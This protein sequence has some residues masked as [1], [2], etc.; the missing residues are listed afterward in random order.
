M[1]AKPLTLDMI[2]DNVSKRFTSRYVESDGCW[3]WQGTRVAGYGVL[4]IGN[5]QYKAHR[6]AYLLGH[7]KIREDMV[8]DH[9]CDNRA[10]VKPSHLKQVT[11]REN[12]TRSDFFGSD[13]ECKRGHSGNFG[14]NKKGARYCRDC[15]NEYQRKKYK[16]NKFM[17]MTI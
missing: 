7:G 2:N 1:K 8:L 4:S 6:I 11:S 15:T 16:E 10:C 9:L 3:E 5:S 13:S 12:T 17:E 14:T